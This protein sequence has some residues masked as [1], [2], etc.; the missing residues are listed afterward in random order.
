MSAKV[1]EQGIPNRDPASRIRAAQKVALARLT[2][3]RSRIA[4]AQA[5]PL[6]RSAQR[7]RRASCSS[8]VRRKTARPQSA[9]AF[10]QPTL[11]GSEICSQSLVRFWTVPSKSA[12]V[13]VAWREIDDSEKHLVAWFRYPLDRPWHVA[14]PHIQSNRSMIQ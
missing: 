8:K 9:A 13:I 3:Q 14:Y 7:D 2:S 10:P 4:T 6:F 12:P 5:E 1:S 11:S